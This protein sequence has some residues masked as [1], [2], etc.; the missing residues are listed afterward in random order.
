MRRHYF[1]LSI[2]E[3]FLSLS[4]RPVGLYFMSASLAPK[5]FNESAMFAGSL[6][7]IEKIFRSC[8]TK[9]TRRDIYGVETLFDENR[10]GN[11]IFG[12]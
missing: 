5:A 11:W 10:K 1:L 4:N 6:T 8:V 2:D 12:G 3:L 9:S 7:K